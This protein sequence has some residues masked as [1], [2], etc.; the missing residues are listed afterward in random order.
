[1]ILYK[2][3]GF[4]AGLKILETQTLGF[5]LPGDFNDPFEVTA[6]GLDGSNIGVRGDTAAARERFIN[7]YAVLSLT[8]APLNPLMWSHY[9]DSHKG[10]VIG[11]DVKKAGLENIDKYIIPAQRGE[12][13]YLNSA[14]QKNNCF[15]QRTLMEIGTSEFNW[16]NQEQLLKQAFLYK[17]LHWAYEEEVRVVKCLDNKYN[18]YRSDEDQQF[19]IDGEPWLK[20]MVDLATNRFIF[21]KT[22]P[23]NAFV[24]VYIGVNCYVDQIRRNS[25]KGGQA[26]TAPNLES[27]K[28]LCLEKK[29]DLYSVSVDL[30]TWSLKR[31]LIR[32]S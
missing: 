18:L 17:G 10:M 6:L 32:D 9:A 12:M 31:N 19:E 28:N 22:I 23:T 5:T 11:I 29:I 21:L 20:K 4:E 27:L 25:V 16:Q 13:I 2:Y 3:V 8:R 1:M 7:K 26:M 15:T 24:E 14:P 30:N